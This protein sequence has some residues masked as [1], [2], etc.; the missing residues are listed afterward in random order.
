MKKIFITGIA[1]FIGFHLAMHLQKRGD[2]VFG[3][4]N[5][6]PYYDPSLKRLRASLLQKAGVK[7]YEGDIT[8]LTT[9][10]QPATHLVHLAAQA[11]VRRSFTHPEEYIRNNV[12]GFSTILELCKH[13]PT[14]TLIYAS[15]SSVYG[16]NKKVPFSEID[17][18][19]QPANL[20]GATKK[21]NELMAA[22][23]HHLFGIRSIG[24]RYFTVYGPWGR[25]DMAYFHFADHLIKGRPISVFN[26]GKMQRDFTYID[27]IVEG[28][29]AA[30]DSNLACEIINLGNH[31]PSSLLALI[32][33]LE[34]YLGK[35][36]TKNLLPAPKGESLSTFADITK[37][38]KLL[39]FQPRTILKK[40]LA[41]FVEWFLDFTTNQNNHIKIKKGRSETNGTT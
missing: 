20:Y 36:A 18:T 8:D 15:S 7:I 21:A 29:V 10:P 33:L 4:D 17:K 41:N 5:F 39:G 6:N 23:Y 11:G 9:L 40:G 13:H 32:E 38:K 1:G 3:L 26:Y 35:K 16:L 24:L 31:K 34:N 12:Q 19:D 27:D 25:P 22:S 14:M 28:T 37:A 30:I 2:H